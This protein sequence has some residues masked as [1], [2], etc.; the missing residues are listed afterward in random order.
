[1]SLLLAPP[2]PHLRYKDECVS[3][4]FRSWDAGVLEKLPLFFQES[5]PFLLTKRSAIDLGIVREMRDDLIN[6]KGFKV[7]TEALRQ[8]H[9]Q[10]YHQSP[11]KYLNQVL[12]N[13]FCK[14]ADE[15]EAPARE[16]L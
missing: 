2:S 12:W 1:M 10:V 9:L 16:D 11:M 13:D 5:F 7:T 15:R 14:T 8:S 4:T 6:S 3:E